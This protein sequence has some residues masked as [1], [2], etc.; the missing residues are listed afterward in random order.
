MGRLRCEKTLHFGSVLRRRAAVGHNTYFL[1]NMTDGAQQSGG[2]CNPGTD[3]GDD[4][5]RQC[6]TRRPS[7]YFHFLT[8]VSSPTILLTGN[9]KFCQDHRF[10]PALR[11]V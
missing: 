1:S 2:T 11:N 9:G 6:R 3:K 10:S 7:L 4:T 5:A 8:L